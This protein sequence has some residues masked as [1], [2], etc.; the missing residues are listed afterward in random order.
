[1]IPSAWTSTISAAIIASAQPPSTSARQRITPI[2]ERESPSA[3][4]IAW[5][6]PTQTRIW[7]GTTIGFQSSPRIPGKSTGA[8]SSVGGKSGSSAVAVRRVI[9]SIRSTIRLRSVVCAVAGKTTLPICQAK[10]VSGANA[11][12]NASE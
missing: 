3:T 12:V 6:T 2:P 7:K 11:S 1:M 4:K 9:R 10:L 8:S 5:P